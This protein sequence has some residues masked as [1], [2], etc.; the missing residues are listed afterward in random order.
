MALHWFR[1]LFGP[2][3]SSRPGK[4]RRPRS[5]ARRA[6]SL[7]LEPLETRCL[8]SVGGLDPSFSS[9]PHPGRTLTSFGAQAAFHAAAVAVDSSGRTLVAGTL[10]GDFVLARYT[11]DG[12]LDT[13][14]G[15]GN[16]GKVVTD[17][18]TGSDDQAAG[19]AV[20][21]DGN[22]V[23][24]GTSNHDFAVVRYTPAGVLDTTF[25]T[26][27]SGKV[28]TDLGAV[29]QVAGVALQTNGNDVDIVVA[30]TSNNDFAVVRYTPAGVLDTTF[31]TAN[32]GKV[33]TDIGT[34]S[35]DQ[36]AGLVVQADGKIV[37]AGTSNHD[38]ALARYSAA[39]VLDTTFGTANSGK[40]TTDFN[41][42]SDDGAV[43]IAVQPAGA[44][45]NLVVAGN[46]K[47]EFALARY[48]SAGVLDTTF[49]TAG[50]VVTKDLS[51]N[52]AADGQSARAYLAA[53]GVRHFHRFASGAGFVSTD[54]AA[55]LVVQPDGG[56]IVV[57]SS[58]GNF[59]LARYTSNGVL[60]VTFGANQT[61]TV[62]TDLGG[63]DQAVAAAMQAAPGAAASG[64][65]RVVVAGDSGNRLALARYFTAADDAPTVGV[66]AQGPGTNEEAPVAVT[67]VSVADADAGSLPI[68]V[69]LKVAHGK[70]T[71]KTDV[72]NGVGAS[73]AQGNGTGVVTVTGSLAAINTTLAD[74]NGLTY[75][76]VL[77]FNGT[78]TLTVT[79]DDQG[80]TGD[81]GPRTTTKTLTI[82]VNA[83]ND[84]PVLTAG[85]VQN[86][87][88]A[89]NSGR[90]SLG[91]GG[92]NFGPGGGADEASQTLVFKTTAV[93]S[94]A[95]GT[96]ELADH[97]AVAADTVLTL[98]QLRGL[99]F[100]PAQDATGQ[101]TFTFTVKDN[102]G[103]A[104]GGVD[105]LTE[106]ITITV[107]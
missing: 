17:V 104:N 38:F 106:S 88:V 2:V 44:G 71:V 9:L 5:P 7:G 32:S 101:G 93:P 16:S 45:F 53:P 55:G 100:K 41:A 76:G 68:T 33:T 98:A 66:P 107:N 79:A 15:T 31:G 51:P 91:L 69:T 23:V 82:T 36:A 50:K 19:I 74:A 64:A 84:V 34:S 83:V 37:V 102:G 47:N 20:Q 46:S 105:T 63:A 1:R 49:G 97:T 14:F 27:N 73:A 65:R 103:T 25:G 39:G 99:Q 21:P 56:V 96:V 26:G 29:E 75:Q 24:A 18:G 10:N 95:L 67:G 43:G 62:V 77:D 89:K 81:G 13:T 78:D 70:L 87:T 85:T 94:A 11:A 22:I 3:S 6:L 12:A 40:V 58:N 35:T 92:V 42:G 52:P 4:A 28:V 90:T 8:L 72:A 30:G 59:A 60:D 86:L 80:H 48:T 54:H 61:G 57:G